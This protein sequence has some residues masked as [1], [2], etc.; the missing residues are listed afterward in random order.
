MPSKKN[1]GKSEFLAIQEAIGI[2]NRTH[3]RINSTTHVPFTLPCLFPQSN[4]TSMDF[5]ARHATCGLRRNP[6]SHTYV[7]HSS[8]RELEVFTT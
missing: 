1:G 8:L 4:S 7:T 2:G 3:Y 5:T 6:R